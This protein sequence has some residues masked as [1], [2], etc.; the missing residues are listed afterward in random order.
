[1]PD[2]IPREPPRFSGDSIRWRGS[3][4][5]TTERVLTGGAG[6]GMR[7]VLA[8]QD[9]HDAMGSDRIDHGKIGCTAETLRKWVRQ[10]ER[11]D[12]K[13]AGL[14][15]DERLRELERKI[16]SCASERDTDLR[17]SVPERRPG[18]KPS[19]AGALPRIE[20]ATGSGSEP[21]AEDERALVLHDGLVVAEREDSTSAIREADE[22][23]R[24]IGSGVH[25]PGTVVLGTGGAR[26]ERSA[27]AARNM[28][29]VR[30]A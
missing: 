2:S 9:T 8:Q 16:G 4:H 25:A 23:V 13:R 15:T 28:L 11:D 24:P 29:S 1:M 22:R 14:T 20:R 21:G 10:R 18:S 30:A 12:E 19:R 3:S 5:G 6:A 26:T 7:L 27:R 17:E